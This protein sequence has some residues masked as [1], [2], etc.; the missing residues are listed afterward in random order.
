[1]ASRVWSVSSNLT[2]RPVFFCLTVARSIAYPF[3]AMFS[4][5]RATTSQPRSLL[6]IARL[7]MARS[8]VRPWTTATN[9]PQ[10]GQMALGHPQPGRSLIGR[11]KG[12]T[13]NRHLFR[14]L[15]LAGPNFM[16]DNCAWLRA[17][18]H[19]PDKCTPYNSAVMGLIG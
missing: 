8:R 16:R 17:G 3:G 10:A 11:Q 1:M 9:D 2:G 14:Q 19:A 13:A 4:T 18:V 12:R 7:N 15:R 5:L 6:S